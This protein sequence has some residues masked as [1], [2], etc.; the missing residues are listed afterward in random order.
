GST[1]SRRPCLLP[2][3][4]LC[5]PSALGP[6]PPD[7]IRSIMLRP[8]DPPRRKEHPVTRRFAASCVYSIESRFWLCQVEGVRPTRYNALVLLAIDVGNTNIVLGGY[9][10]EHLVASWRV[11]TDASRMPD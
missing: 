8:T 11:N 6:G 2:R 9:D 5:M 10:G 4:A 3:C 7:T 1:T